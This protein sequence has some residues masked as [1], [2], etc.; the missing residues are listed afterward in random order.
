MKLV[1]MAPIFIA[2]WTVIIFG[3]IIYMIYKAKTYYDSHLRFHQ[4]KERYPELVNDGRVKC[5]K[6]NS[7]QIHIRASKPYNLHVCKTCGN[8]LYISPML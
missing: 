7:G 6:C 4:Y 3:I 8:V 1:D 5:N 2:V